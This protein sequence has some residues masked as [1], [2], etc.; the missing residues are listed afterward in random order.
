MQARKKV[1]KFLNVKKR[2]NGSVNFSFVLFSWVFYLFLFKLNHSIIICMTSKAKKIK[3]ETNDKCLKCKFLSNNF[4]CIQNSSLDKITPCNDFWH[5]DDHSVHLPIMS[6]GNI[7]SDKQRGYPYSLF[8][9]SEIPRFTEKYGGYYI[10]FNEACG[11]IFSDIKYDNVK[12]FKKKHSLEHILSRYSKKCENLV[13]HYHVKSAQDEENVHLLRNLGF[14][15]FSF[16]N[17]CDFSLDPY[18]YYNELMNH[19]DFIK[20]IRLLNKNLF[21]TFQRKEKGK[22][23]KLTSFQ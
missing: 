15:V 23:R 12:Y 21:G 6:S 14:C 7:Y 19:E 2:V 8:K 9:S 18:I 1:K 4:C 22:F 16:L 13:L 5:V 3:M 11:L 20:E 10:L 17:L